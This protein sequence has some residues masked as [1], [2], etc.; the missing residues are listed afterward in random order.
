MSIGSRVIADFV[1]ELTWA[2]VWAGRYL[3]KVKAG[4]ENHLKVENSL[5]GLIK[6]G[7]CLQDAHQAQ[8]W[9]EK[10]TK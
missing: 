6:V 2:K 8:F 4:F 9:H 1:F 5:I 10:L 7:T 3:N